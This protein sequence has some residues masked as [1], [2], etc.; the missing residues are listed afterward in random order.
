M[1]RPPKPLSLVPSSSLVSFSPVTN[2]ARP[3]PAH[4]ARR[5]EQVQAGQAL[6]AIKGE[7]LILIFL[8]SII[9]FIS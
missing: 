3:P 1:G 9:P 2:S 5:R 7:P 6:V 4:A 8:I